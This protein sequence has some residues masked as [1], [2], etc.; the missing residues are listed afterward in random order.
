MYEQSALVEITRIREEEET[1]RQ[2][3]R[4]EEETKRQLQLQMIDKLSTT[5]KKDE[6]IMKLLLHK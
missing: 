5:E 6:A 1:K 2:A 3:K 4:E